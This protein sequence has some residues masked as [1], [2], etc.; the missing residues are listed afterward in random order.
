MTSDPFPLSLSTV[1]QF[2]GERTEALLKMYA[3]QVRVRRIGSADEIADAVP[4][5]MKRFRQWDYVD[6]RPRRLVRYQFVAVDLAP[7]S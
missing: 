3:E 6:G 2:A 5:L 7:V 4:F 1:D